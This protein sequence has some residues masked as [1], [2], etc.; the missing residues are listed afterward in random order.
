MIY[1]TASFHFLLFSRFFEMFPFSQ[2]NNFMCV[3]A[4]LSD[5][6]V[7]ILCKKQREDPQNK[8]ILPI[9]PVFGAILP[10]FRFFRRF[11]LFYPFFK[12]ARRRRRKLVYGEIHFSEDTAR[13]T[14][15]IVNA[16]SAFLFGH[17]AGGCVYKQLC[18][19]FN[20]DNRENTERNEKNSA[21]V[22]PANSTGKTAPY[23]LRNL[24]ATANT[25]RAASRLRNSHGKNDGVYGL[26]YRRGCV[27]SA[28]RATVIASAKILTT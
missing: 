14:A 6:S 17:C 9:L 20:S 5:Y 4:V 26:H 25:A 24:I 13:I 2:S 11:C 22:C 18:G 28:I 1:L 10:F 8:R 21:I 7:R 16:I 15:R 12:G 23:R 3:F 19:A 27:C